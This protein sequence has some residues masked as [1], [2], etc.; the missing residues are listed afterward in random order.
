[1]GCDSPEGSG[2]DQTSRSAVTPGTAYAVTLKRA[3][4]AAIEAEAFD[5]LPALR[6][7]FERATAAA[8]GAKVVELALLRRRRDEAKP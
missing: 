1:M 2:S 4:Q 3:M 5:E 8:G 6:G 7:M